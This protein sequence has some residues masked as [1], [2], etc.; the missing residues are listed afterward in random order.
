[1]NFASQSY[2]INQKKKLSKLAKRKREKEEAKSRCS[3]VPSRTSETLMP[4]LKKSASEKP[5][6]PP[7]TEGTLGNS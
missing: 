5:T 6:A 2:H 1:M 4:V 3:S 7:S